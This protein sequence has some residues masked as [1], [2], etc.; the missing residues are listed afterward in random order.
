MTL[1]SAEHIVF[2]NGCAAVPGLL[3][4]GYGW[5]CADPVWDMNRAHDL[6][7]HFVTAFLLTELKGDPEAAKA[8]VPETVSFPGIQYETIGLG[9]AGK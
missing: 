4:A 1:E 9:A 3:E 5:A 8:L 2:I 6:I 7:N